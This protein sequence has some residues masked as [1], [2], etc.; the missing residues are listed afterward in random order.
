LRSREKR[1]L[2]DE[3]E[4]MGLTMFNGTLRDVRLYGC[5]LSDREV[6][7]LSRESK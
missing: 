6:Q 7:R 1:R 2:G 5:A 4:V 3:L